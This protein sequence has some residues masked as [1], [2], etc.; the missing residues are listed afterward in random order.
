MK[1]IINA[2]LLTAVGS[3]SSFALPTSTIEETPARH[4]G[5]PPLSMQKEI[6]SADANV[7]ADVQ[8]E[9]VSSV[10]QAFTKWEGRKETVKKDKER[11][12]LP[13]LTS[14]LASRPLSERNDLHFSEEGTTEKNEPRFSEEEF[15]G[16]AGLSTTKSQMFDPDELGDQEALARKVDDSHLIVKPVSDPIKGINRDMLPLEQEDPIAQQKAKEKIDSEMSA[17]QYGYLKFKQVVV[18]FL[19]MIKSWFS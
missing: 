14:P 15:K 6:V 8:V 1:K 3:G 11:E 10:A 18:G 5:S 4:A 16:F 7:K 9:K 2:L 19:N 12:E 13:L 17:V